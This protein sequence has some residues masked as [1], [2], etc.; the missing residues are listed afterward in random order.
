MRFIDL[1]A[2]V[3]EGVGDDAALLPYISSANIACGAHAG[4]LATMHATVRLAGKHGVSIG[5]HPGFA[6][7]AHFGRIELALSSAEIA[8]LVG[9]QVSLLQTVARAEGQTVYHVKLHGALYNLAARSAEVAA[10][11]V[12]TVFQIDRKLVLYALARSELSEAGYRRGLVVAE[13]VF[14]DRAYLGNGTLVPRSEAGAVISSKFDVLS[15]AITV[16]GGGEVYARDGTGFRRFATTFCL[17]GDTPRVEETARFLRRG[18]EIAGYQ[19]RRPQAHF[20]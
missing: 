10:V 18:L 16:A 13:E 15:R 11:V 8:T 7:R 12:E 17:H 2:D 19:L 5:A 4:D 1:N 3:G 14:L 6:D 9:E 20:S